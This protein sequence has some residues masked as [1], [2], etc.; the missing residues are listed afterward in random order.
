MR[1]GVFFP[2][3]WLH[4]SCSCH[5]G[6]GRG[7]R[8]R[9]WWWGWQLPVVGWCNPSLPGR[10]RVIYCMKQAGRHLYD[11]FI[12]AF[13]CL[14]ACLCVCVW[15]GRR[16]GGNEMFCSEL[17][18]RKLAPGRLAATWSGLLSMRRHVSD[19]WWYLE[20]TTA[21]QI[22]WLLPRIKEPMA[23][24]DI[25]G[26]P[27]AWP[28]PLSGPWRQWKCPCSAWLAVVLALATLLAFLASLLLTG[29]LI[30][31]YITNWSH[32]IQPVEKCTEAM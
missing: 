1:N 23:D 25:R 13:P 2:A 9:H 24:L 29:Y 26:K 28:L 18:S 7:W 19:V 27:S 30:H 11:I 6:L 3:V 31:I 5:T 22:L 16:N 8:W 14:P 20:A 10:E 12:S 32:Q 15:P 17:S 21:D 4:P